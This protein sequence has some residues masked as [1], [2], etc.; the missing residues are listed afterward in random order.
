MAMR[1]FTNPSKLEV[2][3][4]WLRNNMEAGNSYS[5]GELQTRA[6]EDGIKRRT[7]QLAA[8]YEA[9][10]SPQYGRSGIEAWQWKLK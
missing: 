6:I 4:Q 3:R 5:A 10:I 7:L 2:A 8:T 1:R 9:D